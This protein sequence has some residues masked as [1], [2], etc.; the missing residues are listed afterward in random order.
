MQTPNYLFFLLSI[1]PKT[2]HSFSFPIHS[3]ISPQNFFS[4]FS[5]LGSRP[6]LN[7]NHLIPNS[8]STLRIVT[9]SQSPTPSYRRRDQLQRFGRPLHLNTFS[10]LLIHNHHLHPLCRR[11][12]Y[13][14]H[15]RWLSNLVWHFS[16][17][18][19]IVSKSIIICL[20]FICINH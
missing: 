8:E 17:F 12:W 15:L 16:L 6:R 5:P 11:W 20:I 1:R 14:H 13:S 3:L 7:P 2:F 4:Y 19:I 10:F 9:D 18:S